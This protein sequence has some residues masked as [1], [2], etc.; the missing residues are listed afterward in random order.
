MPNTVIFARAQFVS[1]FLLLVGLIP[2][3]AMAQP[4][5]AARL[6]LSTAGDEA[7]GASRFL[8]MTADG[9]HVVFAS[10]AS[11]LVAGDTNGVEDLFVRDRDTDRDGVFDEPGAVATVRINVSTGG[12]E[13]D[14]HSLDVRLSAD[15]R[16]VCFSTVAVTLVPGDTNGVIDVFVR[17]R[18]VDGDGVFDEAD[19]VST[20]RVSTGAGEVQGNGGSSDPRITPDGR[21]VVFGSA[22]TNFS[23]LPT[24]GVTQI[25][26]KD[27]LSGVL[28]LVSARPGGTPGDLGSTLGSVSDDGRIVVFRTDAHNLGMPDA[29]WSHVAV[30][31]LSAN[32]VVVLP[33]NATA[34]VSA[35]AVAA[36]L[37]VTYPTAEPGVTPDGSTVYFGVAT[38]G[39]VSPISFTSGTLFEYTVA[40]GQIRQIA[41]SLDRGLTG[42][43]RYL[44]MA[45][46][47]GS[48]FDSCGYAS[49]Q[50]AMYDRLHRTNAML[51]R[52]LYTH[53]AS[54][55]SFDRVLLRV[56]ALDTCPVGSPPTISYALFDRRFGSLVN[57]P[58]VRQ[59]LLNETGSEVVFET[60]DSTILPPGA[61]VNA[62]A[63]V[64]AVDIDSRLDQDGDLLDDR[65]E[66]ATGLSYTSAAGAN[67]AT[68][69][70]DN[71]GLTNQQELQAG[72]HPRG[73]AAR[74]LA[75]GAEN[76]FFHTRLALANTGSTPATAVVRLLAQGGGVT[77]AFVSVPAM[78]RHTVDIADIAGLTAES[79]SFVVESDAPLVVDRTMSWDATGYGAHAERAVSAPSTTWFLAE[80][81][82]TGTFSLFY[83][84]QNPNAS[85]VTATVRYLRP[86]GAPI[87]KTYTLLA[88]SRTTIP[89]NS[90]APELASTDVSAAITADQPIFVERAMY[91]TRDG[92]PFAAGHDSAGVTAAGTSWFLAEGATGSF[93]D[94]FILI[95][96]PSSTDAD[97]EIRYLL[98]GGQVLTKQY[99]VAA[100]SRRTIWVDGEEFPGLGR[101]LAN[102]SL[103]ST[104]TSLNSVPIV[105]ERTMWFPGPE[106]TSRFWTEAHN[107]PGSTVAAPRWALAEGEI[108]GTAL[109]R[110]YVLIANP[111]T[112]AARVR[113]TL[114]PETG[115]STT[116]VLTVAAQSRE[117]IDL[118]APFA[119]PPLAPPPRF[120]A[121]VESIAEGSFTVVP[122]VV[123]RAMY[124]N[125]GET[126]WAAG[127]NALGTPIP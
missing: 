10:L 60:G 92:Q 34:A 127:T 27:R 48:S 91:L 67:G 83:L 55:G 121:I 100:N 47:E 29:A 32:T 116:A 28:S 3:P 63:D 33:F 46:S 50:L 102:F 96:N 39:T 97:V 81:S 5:P 38:L 44:L 93:F 1:A 21:Y 36:P 108:G 99:A 85:A 41:N 84:L 74:Y 43:G 58:D 13:A 6:S 98:Q 87:E 24:N 53:A 22:A 104:V 31:D 115:A 62:V 90:E 110:T 42:G 77:P 70:P 57:L 117:T 61:D 23:P 68:G 114:L 79:F 125:A 122:I 65:W 35:S 76:A 111:S 2:R 113:I 12:A 107:S 26:R 118:A 52:G 89:V 69:D 123:E 126:V 49:Y 8:R 7:N 82:T 106:M 105:V 51:F 88:N 59:G 14:A 103:S 4:K 45:T 71:D 80:G 40:T 64:F 56:V 78:S 16:F 30:R 124:W 15:G 19:A 101:V 25:Y 17:D 9:R 72:S 73:S 119:L 120:G 11:N 109:M 37:L 66:S 18:D 86:E 54:S 95:A 75:E 112:S 20:T 94:M